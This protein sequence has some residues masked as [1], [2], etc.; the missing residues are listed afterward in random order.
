MLATLFVVI[1]V[2]FIGVGLPDSILGPAWPAMYR[3]FGLP[4]SLAGYITAAVSVGTIISSLLSARLIKKFG[5]GLVS[6]VSTLLTALA[7]LGFAFTKNPI[8]FFILSLPLGIGAGAIDTALNNFSALYYS[9]SKISFL[10]CSYGLGVAISPFIMSLA[11]GENENWRRGYIIVALIQLAIAFISFIALPLW[12]KI[13]KRDGEKLVKSQKIL[14]IPQL[15]KTSGVFL[16]GLAFF[17]ACALELTAGAWCSSFFVNAKGTSSE[18][19]AIITM[20]FY[21]G[22]TFGRLLSGF[23]VNLLGSKKILNISVFTMLVSLVFFVLPLP[24]IVSA[25]A[26]LMLGIGVAPVFPNLMHLTPK[27]FGIEISQ[28][29]IGFQQ[30][31]TYLGIM[32]M[33]WLFGMLAD[34]FGTSLLPFYLIAIFIIYA[35]AFYMLMYVIKKKND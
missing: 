22:L 34:A 23:F 8:F 35:F 17:A 14:S 10:H 9:A 24:T 32:I 1:F 19:A 15:I 30:S 27:I 33:P 5:T 2:S 4:I 11:L 7:L 28:S 25:I 21:I 6:A 20:I 26:L 13:E 16:S 31:M 3:E 18:K 29:V 12:F